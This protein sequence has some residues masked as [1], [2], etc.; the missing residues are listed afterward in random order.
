M[1]G[2][3]MCFGGEQA[4]MRVMSTISDQNIRKHHWAFRIPA[5]ASQTALWHWSGSNSPNAIAII[6]A[7]MSPAALCQVP[8]HHDH[9]H[10]LDL[11]RRLGSI[12]MKWI[13]S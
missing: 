7:W 2:V 8:R 5:N 9:L 10:S 3:L 11:K 13:A 4:F 6:A 12:A 1:T